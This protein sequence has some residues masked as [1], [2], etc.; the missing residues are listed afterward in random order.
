M[1]EPHTKKSIE[2]HYGALNDSLEKQANN[3]GYTLGDKAGQLEKYVDE[4]I[5]LWI[6]NLL[7]DKEKDK[8]IERL[9]KKIIKA[10]KCIEEDGN[11][12]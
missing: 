4:I 12:V 6:N 7:T 1:N 10:I 11:N 5:D 3:Q 9:H 2:F 8:S